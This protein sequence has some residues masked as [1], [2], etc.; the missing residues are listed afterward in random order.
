MCAAQP[1]AAG[2]VT[3]TVEPEVSKALA[4]IDAA[5]APAQS[6]DP[7]AVPPSPATA[8]NWPT[9]SA[10]AVRTNDVAR[11]RLFMDVEGGWVPVDGAYRPRDETP[12]R[13]PPP[14]AGAA[15]RGAGN[16][17]GAASGAGLSSPAP[18]GWPTGF[19]GVAAILA[20]AWLASA[21]RARV[22]WRT[23]AVG[24]GT[25][26]AIAFLLLRFPPAVAA[27]D[28]LA[29]VV[30]RVIS[31]SDE[32]IRFVFGSLGDGSGPWGFVFAVRVLPII[33]FFAAIVSILY[34]LGVMQ[35]VIALVAWCLRKSMAV[36]G[37]EALSAAANI[38][39]GQTEAPLTIKPFI[40][41]MTRS[42]LM[43]VMTGGFATIAGSV[44]AAY[45]AMVGGTDEAARIEVA[46]HL[47]TASV[48]SAPAGLV[49][50]KILVPESEVVPD[51]STAGLRAMPRTASN[52]VDAAAEG[53]ADGLRLALNVGAMLVA[54]VALIALLN[55]PLAALSELDSRWLPIAT[56]RAELGIPV[57]TFQN[58]LGFVLRPMAW[59]MGAGA[60]SQSL[61][62]LMG[63]Q[64]VA[65]ELVAYMDLS[66]AV[67]D[68]TMSP[69]GV[70]IATFA[71]CGF[72]N[73]P[74]VAIQIGG[75]GAMA[76]ARRADLAR[77]GLRAMCAGALA[78]WMTGAVA[79]IMVR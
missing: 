7:P 78:C 38:F 79:G 74:S 39:V 68:G 56:W 59:L 22:P 42:Q 52:V 18:M 37:V 15:A 77:L 66:Q 13:I 64:V 28:A 47:M 1:R 6:V 45:V 25:Q 23:V 51:E 73:L 54:F 20:I 53:A 67:R 24:V 43:A 5:V 30:T 75:L 8:L 48:M 19:L 14:G 35:R 46:K 34:H 31:F 2:R 41:A 40:P 50:A 11:I 10:E 12:K 55:W 65:T 44:M 29:R 27:F 49:L 4:P 16:F 26:F 76:P 69:R 58:I 62:A 32:G 21:D 63:T 33:V 9:T 70:T 60:D 61:A 72:A 57:L 36:S 71:L 17:R 3:E